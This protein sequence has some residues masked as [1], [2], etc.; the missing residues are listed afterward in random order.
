MPVMEKVP[1]TE[2]CPEFAGAFEHAAIGMALVA[3][4]GHFMQVNRALCRMLGYTAPELLATDSQTLTLP[5]DQ[6]PDLKQ[7]NRVLAGEIDHYQMEKRYRHRSGRPIPVLMSVSLVR[8][9]DGSPRY[10]I[11]QI[12]DLT[13]SRRASEELRVTCKRL[14]TL[15]EH[16]PHGVVLEDER[17]RLLLVNQ[18]FCTLMGLPFEPGIPDYPDGAALYA[19]IRHLFA[20]PDYL[21][22]RM[23]EAIRHRRRISGETVELADGRLLQRDYIPVFVDDSY[24]GHLWTWREPARDGSGRRR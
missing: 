23:E 7:V 21:D 20:R 24:R 4:D 18:A 6:D 19:D 15:T 3:P 22:S 17:R 5:A 10:F 1:F 12:Q 2:D 11:S 8:A 16:L 14:Q 9:V 13:E